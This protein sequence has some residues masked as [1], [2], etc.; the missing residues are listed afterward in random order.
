MHECAQAKFTASKPAYAILAGLPPVCLLALNLTSQTIP[1]L[2]RS[3]P[4]TI[5][6]NFST[7]P[8]PAPAAVTQKYQHLQEQT[9]S[10][11]EH[12]HIPQDSWEEGEQERGAGGKKAPLL[13]R[14]KEWT[15]RFKVYVVIHTDQRQTL[16]FLLWA[17][18]LWCCLFHF[19]FL[20]NT[21]RPI[22]NISSSI[23]G[24]E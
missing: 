18:W 24:K 15:C 9:P 20:L 5:R 21:G 4:H 19:I 14:R 6:Y 7:I 10:L 8:G 1:A 12:H 11:S 17:A 3:H 2:P 13:P 22:R 23:Q 16:F